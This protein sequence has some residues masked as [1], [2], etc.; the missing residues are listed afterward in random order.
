MDLPMAVAACSLNDAELREQLARYRDA[1]KDAEVV[2][3]GERRLVLRVA[4]TV[5]ESLIEGLVEVE[6]GCCPFFELTWDRVSRWLTIEVSTIEH[7]PAL[8]A[9]AFALGATA[10]H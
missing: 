2:E 8:E 7:Q 1:G 9:I 10:A 4:T 6:Q 5:P 3:R